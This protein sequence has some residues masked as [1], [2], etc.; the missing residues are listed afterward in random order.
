MN[1]QLIFSCAAAALMCAACQSSKVEIDGRL[2]SGEAQEVYLEQ[3][4]SMRQQVIDTATL[5][6]EG[7]YRFAL[8]EASTTPSLY[9]ILYD[10][11]RI[12]LFVAAGDRLTVNSVGNLVRN[13]TVEGSDESELMRQFYQAFIAGAQK[14]ENI[15]KQVSVQS[16]PA[17]ERESLLQ[18]YTEEYY[19][20]RREQLR[21][22]A[23]HKA[24]LAAVYAIYQR[25]PGDQHLVDGVSDL[26]HYRTVAE[27]IAESYPETPYLVML[28]G[29]ISRMEA[30]QRLAEEITES[31][32]PDLEMSNIYGQKVKLSSLQGKVIMLD[33]WSAEL[34]NSNQLN[35]E[36]KEIY[37]KYKDAATPFEVYQVAV[38][39]SKPLWINTVQ[40][41]QLPWISVS[42]LRGRASTALGTYNVTKL[43]TSFLI[44]KEGEIV[45]RDLR[46]AELERKL[47]ELTR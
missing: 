5:D 2:L 6:A 22:I 36:L 12:P 17:T 35:A 28:R 14:L 11:E 32:F 3:V 19:R 34:G 24:S 21:F 43:P 18:Q 1:K 20:I 26:I 9:N 10:G 8:E 31:T 40:E 30:A 27:A 16:L 44:D 7:N 33:F 46:G 4:S 29:D 39:T 25:L 47:Q 45:A 13:Y 41:Q 37:A 15:A 42:D 23:E 38:D